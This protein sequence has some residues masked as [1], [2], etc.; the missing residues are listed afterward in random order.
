VVDLPSERTLPLD[1]EILGKIVP[2]RSNTNHPENSF[3]QKSVVSP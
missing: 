1:V 3:D 2:G